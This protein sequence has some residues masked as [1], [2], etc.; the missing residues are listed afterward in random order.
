MNYAVIN[1]V[2]YPVATDRDGLQWRVADVGGEINETWEDWSGGMG[3]CERKS[4]RGYYF[5]DGF[6]ATQQGVLRLSPTVK[7]L[8]S[9]ALSTGHGYFFEAT[10]AGAAPTYD[11]DVTGDTA[12]VA[13]TSL[14]LGSLKIGRAHV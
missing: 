3:E 6:D 9:V 8:Q 10:G 11:T 7:S 13:A 2:K 1:S 5:S 12:G 4:K 14:T